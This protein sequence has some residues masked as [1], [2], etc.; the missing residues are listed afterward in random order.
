MK[1][2]WAKY[3]LEREGIHAVEEP[4]GFATYCI[5]NGE[6]YIQ[7]IYI[8]P[9]ERRNNRAT[10]LANKIKDVALSEGCTLLT[11]SVD[12]RDPSRTE[13]ILVLIS[14]GMRFSHIKG[15]MLIFTMSIGE[16]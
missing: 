15:H 5:G 11:G 16:Q 2:L 14:Y 9:E 8:E 12:E 3:K 6:C 4:W 1:S 10:E 7:D 13:N